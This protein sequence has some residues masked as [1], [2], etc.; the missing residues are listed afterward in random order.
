MSVE[1][2]HGPLRID[3]T[4]EDLGRLFPAM[5]P[6]LPGINQALRQINFGKMDWLPYDR[7]VPGYHL[8]M[9]AALTPQ[10][11]GRPP[12]V[13]HW[14]LEVS[15]EDRSYVL[16]L[17]GKASGQNELAVL[18]SPCGKLKD[19]QELDVYKLR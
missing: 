4:L 12:A 2:P 1:E 7:E 5:E 9:R 10:G 8:H 15:R 13:G 11:E 19:F 14:Q 18:V 3:G 6:L 17:Q 16:L